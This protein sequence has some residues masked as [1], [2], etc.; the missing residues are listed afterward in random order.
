MFRIKC[1]PAPDGAI[2]ID[3][4]IVT[5]WHEDTLVLAYRK[6]TSPLTVVGAIAAALG[7]EE[8]APRRFERTRSRK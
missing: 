3:A 2:P 1:G 8:N 7:S 5:T 4:E 6:D